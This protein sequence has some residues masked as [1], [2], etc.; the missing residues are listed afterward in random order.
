MQY[1]NHFPQ[2]FIRIMTARKCSAT[3]VFLLL[4]L[5]TAPAQLPF[6]TTGR[7]RTF[8][9]TSPGIGALPDTN[10]STKGIF[11]VTPG[12]GYWLAR[13]SVYRTSDSGA[14]WSGVS[15]VHVPHRMFPD[16]FCLSLDG[17][18][19]ADG[20]MTWDS[21]RLSFATAERKEV[22]LM[23]VAM[24]RDRWAIL[25]AR[26]DRGPSSTEVARLAWTTD[27]GR[28]WTLAD[29]MT[30]PWDRSLTAVL[31]AGG[32]PT[33]AGASEQDYTW[34]FVGANPDSAILLACLNFN[35]WGLD[36]RVKRWYIGRIDI[37][38]GTVQWGRLLSTED[39]YISINLARNAGPYIPQFPTTDDGYFIGARPEGSRTFRD[40]LY[41]TSDGGLTW[42]SI[43]RI[44]PGVSATAIKVLDRDRLSC[45]GWESRD[46]GSSWVCWQNPYGG[47]QFQVVDSLSYVIAGDG[48]FFARTDDAGHHWRTNGAGASPT[49]VAASRGSLY[50]GDDQGSLLAS[51]D[52]GETWRGLGGSLPREVQRLQGLT[53]ADAGGSASDL[54]AIGFVGPR[55]CD[56]ASNILLASTNEGVEW[57]V[58]STISELN[59]DGRAVSLRF[60][61]DPATSQRRL[62]MDGPLGS[63]FSTDSGITW[64]R[65]VL[66]PGVP[67]SP[68][69]L[70]A[71]YWAGFVQTSSDSIVSMVTDDAG[72][73]WTSGAPLNYPNITHE[74]PLKLF[75]VGRDQFRAMARDRITHDNYL[76]LSTSDGGKSW[77]ARPSYNYQGYSAFHWID[78]GLVYAISDTTLFVSWIGGQGFAPLVSFGSTVPLGRYFFIRDTS[79]L[80][81]A[82]RGGT[83]G[84]WR[85][86]GERPQSAVPNGQ[87]EHS[88]RSLVVT[89]DADGGINL[90][91]AFD[92]S[93]LGS[94][95]TVT[96]VDLLGELVATEDRLVESRQC[97]WRLGGVGDLPQGVYV[98]RVACDGADLSG[99][100]RITR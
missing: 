26:S 68:S 11:F 9:A 21:L 78:S 56:S 24:T 89:R 98:V 7:W 39:E 79:Y 34:Q 84:R 42:D 25:Y 62:F 80:F 88:N 48:S 17:F 30:S 54:L 18:A 94:R 5:G 73:T 29:S 58:R 36:L 53:I 57:T 67:Q 43:G 41:R 60:L 71:T 38:R 95:A 4:V 49:A 15:T 20:G 74:A 91:L 2:L 97:K 12:T 1:L 99:A 59:G 75:V 76:L 70:N 45:D 87:A 63:F 32:F 85:I 96:V 33:V 16:G 77:Q 3:L 90:H 8:H 72:A 81:L 46:G 6:D 83:V 13:S 64:E 40:N 50:I 82:G 37:E 14:S 52:S 66:P 61:D 92:A 44:P 47:R 55:N 69:R 28:S 31:L 35:A 100:F 19:S 93:M 10:L 27:R 23:S 51:T 86:G 22:A 65:I